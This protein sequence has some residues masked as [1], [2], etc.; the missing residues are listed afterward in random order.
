MPDFSLTRQMIEDFVNLSLRYKS[1]TDE[2][3]KF[4]TK[5]EVVY[6]EETVVELTKLNVNAYI[7]HDYVSGL[8]KIAKDRTDG[9]L[10]L[11]PAEE[12]NVVKCVRSLIESKKSL[13]ESNI[14][15]EVH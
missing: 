6:P 14:S 2:L 12:A 8:L 1:I 10:E 13:L 15:L 3:I 5:E 7:T 9:T 11:L 4:I